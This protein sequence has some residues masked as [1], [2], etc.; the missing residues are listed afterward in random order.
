MYGGVSFDVLDPSARP[1]SEFHFPVDAP[2]FASVVCDVHGTPSIVDRS[3]VGH[4]T[5]QVIATWS[6]DSAVVDGRGVHARIRRVGERRFVATVER[7]LGPL[8]PHPVEEALAYALVEHCGGI[9][10]HAAAVSLGSEGTVLFIGPSGAGK[11]TACTLTG[12]PFFAQDKLAL[13]PRHDGEWWAWPLTGGSMP[14][15]ARMAGKPA[16]RVAG[17]CRVRRSSPET[18]L[19]EASAHRAVFLVRESCFANTSLGDDQDRLDAIT[20]LCGRVPVA[21]L[22]TVLGSNPLQ[23]LKEWLS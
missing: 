21:E 4:R 11:T 2:S 1:S 9:V 16:L 19:T 6:D 15:D 3:Q 10:L 12:Q 17:I 20:E 8:S 22:D 13:A 14:E 5:K 18:R 7:R 23:V